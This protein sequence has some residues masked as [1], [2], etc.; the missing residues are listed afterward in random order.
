MASIEVAL[1]SPAATLPIVVPLLPSSVILFLLIVPPLSTSYLI[2]L[3]ETVFSWSSVAAW[4]LVIFSASRGSIGQTADRACTAVDSDLIGR[5]N[6]VG[7]I[8]IDITGTDRTVIA[9]DSDFIGAAA[10]LRLLHSTSA[11]DR[12]R[13]CH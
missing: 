8:H 5:N 13:R 2:A 4:P 12:C 10:D 6:A 11:R 9:V 1:T 7:A 3:S